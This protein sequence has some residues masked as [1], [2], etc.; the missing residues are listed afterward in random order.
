MKAPFAREAE[1]E[2]KSK[3]LDV[4]NAELNMDKKENELV[5]DEQE[6]E[7]GTRTKAQPE[8]EE[9]EER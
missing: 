7:E 6:T 1:L 5:D 3:R 4:L 8:R 2:E 9:E